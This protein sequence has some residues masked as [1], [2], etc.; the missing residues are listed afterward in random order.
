MQGIDDARER[1]RKTC[2]VTLD[3]MDKHPAVMLLMFTAV[4]VSKAQEHRHLRKP[5]LMSAFLG[6]SRTARHAAS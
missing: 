6:V 2:W 1:L 5:E 3:Y 4:P